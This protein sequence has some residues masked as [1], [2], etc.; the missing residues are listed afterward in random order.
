MYT[1][2]NALLLN[3]NAEYI[4]SFPYI[5][6]TIHLVSTKYKNRAFLKVCL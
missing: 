3:N 2:V 6:L 1:D 5:K 4:I